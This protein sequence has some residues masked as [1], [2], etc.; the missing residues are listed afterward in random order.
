MR[1]VVGLVSSA[2]RLRDFPQS[3]GVMRRFAHAG[4][5]EIIVRPYRIAYRVA[6]DEVHIL[7]V[8]HGAR[9]LHRRDVE[10]ETGA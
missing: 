6:G 3:G 7:K 9:L 5:R 10:E 1:L 8:H 2:Q 4:V